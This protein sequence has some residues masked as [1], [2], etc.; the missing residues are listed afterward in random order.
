VTEFRDAI[1]AQIEADW[2]IEAE[3]VH[4]HNDAPYTVVAV[5]STPAEIAGSVLAMPEMEAIRKA[6]LMWSPKHDRAAE[7]MARW[8]LPESVIAWVLGE[9]R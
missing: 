2:E 9:D 6:L 5:L 4:L 1:A 3:D 8:P 7:V